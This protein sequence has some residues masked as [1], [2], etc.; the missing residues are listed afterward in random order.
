MSKYLARFIVHITAEID[1]PS[2]FYAQAEVARIA[3]AIDEKVAA[4]TLGLGPT[5]GGAVMEHYIEGLA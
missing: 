3:D 1:G 4:P 2:E 5:V